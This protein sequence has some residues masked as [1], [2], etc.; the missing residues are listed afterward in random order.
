MNIQ[1]SPKSGVF[2]ETAILTKCNFKCIN[3]IICFCVSIL[4]ALNV[5][6][7]QSFKQFAPFNMFKFTLEKKG[8]TFETK[9]EYVKTFLK[10]ISLN[11]ETRKVLN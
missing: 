3:V 10:Q 2:W 1:V 7:N 5:K 11:D 8:S 6:I 9:P 4:R